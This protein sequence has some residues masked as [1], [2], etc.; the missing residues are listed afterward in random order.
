MAVLSGFR[1][2][3]ALPVGLHDGIC[4]GYRRLGRLED[5][6]PLVG[7]DRGPGLAEVGFLV[8]FGRDALRLAL[9]DF[10]LP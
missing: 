9:V 2:V 8:I 5:R 4:R 7:C 3:V 10:P 6:L 1:V